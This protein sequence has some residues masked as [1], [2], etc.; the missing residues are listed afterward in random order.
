MGFWDY[1]ALFLIAMIC[2]VVAKTITGFSRGGCVISAIVG[3]IGAFIGAWLSEKLKFPELLNVS[4]GENNFP[5]V[6]AVIGATLFL[7]VISFLT[8]RNK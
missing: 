8:K 7:S 3:F 5:V 2:G 1:I 6:W 4:V